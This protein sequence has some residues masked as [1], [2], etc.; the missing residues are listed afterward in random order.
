MSHN[1]SSKSGGAQFPT[2]IENMIC[3]T[4]EQLRPLLKLEFD[5]SSAQEAVVKLEMELKETY[6]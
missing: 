3:D 6:C 1:S 5:L 4:I 2:D